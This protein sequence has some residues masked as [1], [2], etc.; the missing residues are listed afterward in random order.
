M[1]I[2][3]SPWRKTYAVFSGEGFT[4]ES[5]SE[6]TS[7]DPSLVPLPD[8]DHMCFRFADRI[9]S[10]V[11]LDDGTSIVMRSDDFNW[12]EKTYFWDTKQLGPGEQADHNKV[13][14]DAEVFLVNQNGNAK[15]ISIE[16]FERTVVLL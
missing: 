13:D 14:F 16:E 4:R 6:V 9:E 3:K 15:R 7:R 11:E 5:R 12:S 10:T 8:S 2:I 1:K